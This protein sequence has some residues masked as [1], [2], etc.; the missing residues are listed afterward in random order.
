MIT[1]SDG[2]T[3][4]QF[5]QLREY[6]EQQCGIALGDE[7]AYLI[8]T[9][10]TK[11]MVES[12]CEDFGEFYKLAKSETG[13][14]LRDKIVD[15]MTTNE[16][17][18]FRD[19]H[20]YKILLEKLIPT[21]AEELAAGKRSVVRIWSGACS[22]GQE[23]YSVAIAVHEHC[24]THA[25]VKPEQFKILGTDI[26]A[27]AL[28]L[29][30]A[31]R[32]DRIAMKRGLDDDVRDRYFKQNGQIWV[33]DETIKKMVEFK[34]FNLQDPLVCL[35]R[36]DI[37]FLRYVAIYFSDAFKKSL[38]AAVADVLSPSG[39]LLVGAVESLRG[40][41]DAF[42]NHTHSGGSYYKRCA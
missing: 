34:K 18:W 6:I 24:R 27:S 1:K 13:T 11:L 4:S 36:F 42:E 26:S 7:K 39:Y 40:H 5:S 23:P 20:P 12:G 2:I 16:T 29:A 25:G 38:L 17:L 21:F 8:D 31:G 33:I 35:G 19:A 41:S 10:L 30:K 15:A 22:T 9:R 32:Y 14:T 28:F 37:A 3:E